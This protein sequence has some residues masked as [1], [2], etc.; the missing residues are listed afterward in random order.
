M[1]CESYRQSLGD[2]AVAGEA[3]S[4][5]LAA[6]L[7]QCG[8][9]ATWL[10]AEQE[11]FRAM[12]EFLS[13][14]ANAEVPVSLVPRVR[15]ALPE[16]SLSAK[17]LAWNDV[18]IPALL[19]AVLIVTTVVIPR[20]KPRVR[21]PVREPAANSPVRSGV[22]SDEKQNFAEVGTPSPAADTQVVIHAP[23]KPAGAQP[24]LAVKVEP[25]AQVAM[26]QFI[27]IAREQPNTAQAIYA[28]AYTDAVAIEP[29]DVKEIAWEPLAI[30]SVAHNGFEPQR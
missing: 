29:I 5:A 2:A 21:E 23:G 8:S 4:P 26:Q 6:H 28:R 24:R 10:A 9:C 13:I 14:R 1:F 15:A 19:A 12:D 18:W 22:T 16:N 20:S 11:L 25:A 30:E 7:Q 27:R 17:H 3:L